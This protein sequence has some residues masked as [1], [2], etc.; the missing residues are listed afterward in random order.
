MKSWLK[1]CGVLRRRQNIFK[2]WE[3]CSRF[4]FLIHCGA[5]TQLRYF[6]LCLKFWLPIG[7]H[8]QPYSRGTTIIH[9]ISRPSGCH[10]VYICLPSRRNE[11]RRKDPWYLPCHDQNTQIRM[12]NASSSRRVGGSFSKRWFCV[13]FTTP[14]RYYSRPAISLHGCSSSQTLGWVDCDLDVPPSCPASQRIPPNSHQPRQNWADSGTLEIQV[15]PTHSTSRW[16]TLY[17]HPM[18]CCIFRNQSWGDETTLFLL[19]AAKSS[20][21]ASPMHIRRRRGIA[22]S[23]Q[24]D[25]MTRKPSPKSFYMSKG[26]EKE[27]VGQLFG[28][29][30]SWFSVLHESAVQK[31]EHCLTGSFLQRFVSFPF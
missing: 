1:A 4:L 5:S 25:I 30:Y 21:Q 29:L 7:L 10:T 27:Q 11:K 22:R 16:D 19:P 8:N 14:T 3:I 18:K 15:N 28:F 2:K 12:Q 13:S 26:W 20:A 6:V 9:K 31:A 24:D 23:E 17:V